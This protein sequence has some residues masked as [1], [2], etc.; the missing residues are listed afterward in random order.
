[1][2]EPPRGGQTGSSNLRSRS[3]ALKRANHFV[4]PAVK[5]SRV[6]SRHGTVTVP[7]L[8]PALVTFPVPAGERT[9]AYEVLFTS[10]ER[11]ALSAGGKWR[12]SALQASVNV[13]EASAT[14]RASESEGTR[15]RT[16]ET[17]SS[18]PRLRLQ[19]QIR[20]GRTRSLEFWFSE[21]I[22]VRN[23]E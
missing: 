14:E 1:M 21:A 11:S 3:N 7:Y 10:L 2:A 18:W 16:R 15:K 20:T 23:G 22:E 9:R 17:L 5:H 13:R 19:R 8:S 12:G 4:V 6:R